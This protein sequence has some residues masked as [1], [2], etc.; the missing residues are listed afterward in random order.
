MTIFNDES[1]L[2]TR[3]YQHV[4]S[5]LFAGALRPG[6]RLS[7]A[8]IAKEIG[9]SHI[10]VREALSQLEHEG[11]IEQIDGRGAFV[12]NITRRE[13][14]ELYDLRTSIEGDLAAKAAR[15]IRQ[16][17]LDRLYELCQ[18]MRRLSRIARKIGASFLQQP[19]GKELL[20]VDAEFHRVIHGAAGNSIASRVLA[21]SQAI[22][23]LFTVSSQVPWPDYIRELAGD[24]KEHWQL[25]RLLAQR[26]A[27]G[28]RKCMRDQ[29]RSARSRVL[30]RSLRASLTPETPAPRAASKRRGARNKTAAKTKSR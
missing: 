6:A 18:E 30:D 24:L 10:P 4:R 12:R 19:V 22:Y 28:A 29:L 21:D 14:A 17:Q 20:A 15:R 23:R 8:G 1:S 25:Y 16:P 7:P 5:R 27:A 2:R 11:L 13:V 26:D 9:A 3:A